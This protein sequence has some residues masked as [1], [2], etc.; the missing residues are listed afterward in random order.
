VVFLRNAVLSCS[1][2]VRTGH[3]D[4]IEGGNKKHMSNF[5]VYASWKFRTLK[6]PRMIWDNNIKFGV[7]GKCCE[8]ATEEFR[9]RSLR[10]DDIPR[11]NCFS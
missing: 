4:Q 8:E 11:N 5:E 1:V 9:A 2:D 7:G 6:R 3:G 10:A